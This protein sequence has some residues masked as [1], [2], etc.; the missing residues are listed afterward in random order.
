MSES[1][2][3]VSWHIGSADN[4]TPGKRAGW[5]AYFYWKKNGQ[6]I[7]SAVFDKD[8]LKAE[9]DRL[10]AEGADTTEYEKAYNKL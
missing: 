6:I 4:A 1:D 10:K 7:K 3:A 8:Q 2:V 9:I 5:K